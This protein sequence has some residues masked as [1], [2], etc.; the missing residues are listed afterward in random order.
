MQSVLLILDVW[1]SLRSVNTSHFLQRDGKGSYCCS[2]NHY[3]PRANERYWTQLPIPHSILNV[4][5][6]HL[7]TATEEAWPWGQVVLDWYLVS[8]LSCFTLPWPECFKVL[9]RTPWPPQPQY[10]QFTTTLK[11]FAWCSIRGS[12][13]DCSRLFRKILIPKMLPW[14][15][16]TSYW[17]WT[18]DP[19]PRKRWQGDLDSSGSGLFFTLHATELLAHSL[20]SWQWVWRNWGSHRRRPVGGFAANIDSKLSNICLLDND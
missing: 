11:M 5:W 20:D 6:S 2:P 14:V 10:S 17:D 16:D 18:A 8:T 1:C 15:F 12:L 3:S 13:P 9:T 7:T 19:H 4:P